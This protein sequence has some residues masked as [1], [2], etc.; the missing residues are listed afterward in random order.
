LKAAVKKEMMNNK[1]L[2]VLLNYIL[3]VRNGKKVQSEQ[4]A[5]ETTTLNGF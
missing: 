2:A 3:Y 1:K 4:N 5:G